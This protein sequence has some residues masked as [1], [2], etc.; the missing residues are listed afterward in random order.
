[1]YFKSFPKTFYKFKLT[2]STHELLDIFARVKFRF[3]NVF[4]SRP[5]TTF[6]ISQGDTPDII[7]H[8]FY[9][10]SEWWWLVLL[11]NDI[12]NPFE[13]IP[14]LGFD[15]LKNNDRFRGGAATENIQKGQDNK[16]ITRKNSVAYIN[17]QGGDSRRDFQTGDII[18][19]TTSVNNSARSQNTIGRRGNQKVLTRVTGPNIDLNET[20]RVSKKII[21]WD[22]RKK[23][24]VLDSKGVGVFQE[25]DGVAVVER[26][27]NGVYRPVLHGKIERFFIDPIDSISHFIDNRT[28]GRVD[29]FYDPIEDKLQNLYARSYHGD[30]G[31]TPGTLKLRGTVLET[32]MQITSVD[33]TPYSE[34]YRGVTEQE[35][36][37]QNALISNSYFA[38]SGRIKLLDDSYKHEAMNLIND[39][40]RGQRYSSYESTQLYN[41]TTKRNVRG[42]GGS[43]TSRIY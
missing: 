43:S 21:C 13:D 26:D 42:S 38:P 9:G 18:M 24:A 7:A 22:P 28:G 41:N 35:V 14:R 23:E 25:G 3:N 20:T 1:M 8:K 12:V 4:S 2:G 32:F 17:R 5:H 30:T 19:R 31:G 15:R 36:I 37:E 10:S 6:S 33:S 27:R 39:L 40:M 16:R 29:P 34:D 11:Y